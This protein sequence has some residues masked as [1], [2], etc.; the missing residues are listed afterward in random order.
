MKKAFF[1]LSANV[2]PAFF[3]MIMPIN[4]L[5]QQSDN[6]IKVYVSHRGEDSIGGRIVYEV[7]EKIASSSRYHLEE[8]EDSADF[9]IDLMSFDIKLNNSNGYM[10]AISTAYIWGPGTINFFCGHRVSVC[11]TSRTAEEISDVLSGMDEAYA[12]SN[13]TAKF[14]FDWYMKGIKK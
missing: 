1:L 12:H 8:N 7:K 9:K 5:S 13:A 11:G 10:S 4:L 2:I 6:R 14:I 3:L